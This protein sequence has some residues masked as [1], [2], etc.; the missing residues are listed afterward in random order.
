MRI[1]VAIS[2]EWVW[3]RP[4]ARGHHRKVRHP[5]DAPL[6]HR[7][8]RVLLSISPVLSHR[9][10]VIAQGAR[11][12]STLC[13]YLNCSNGHLTTQ[14]VLPHPCN[15]FTGACPVGIASPF[16]RHTCPFGASTAG[17]Q[18]PIGSYRSGPDQHI[19]LQLIKNAFPPN[20]SLLLPYF[21]S[22]PGWVSSLC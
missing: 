13:P 10:G 2:G 17:A 11:A 4:G 9:P 5:G 22:S 1:R 21:V 18:Q 7:M 8:R 19:S 16:T 15:R 12:H 20:V 14:A 3:M 6:A